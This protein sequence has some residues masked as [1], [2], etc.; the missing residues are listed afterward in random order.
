VTAHTSDDFLDACGSTGPVEILV[1]PRWGDEERRVLPHPFA[2]L[3]RLPTADLVVA[4]EYVSRRHAYL[5]VIAGRLFWIDLLSRSGCYLDE[6]RRPCGWLD[7]GELRCGLH[8]FRALHQGAEARPTW[9]PLTDD[10]PQPEPLA[11]VVLTF[12]RYA[13]PSLYWKPRP[14]VSLIGSSPICKLRTRGDK[15]SRINCVLVRTARGAWIVDL[16]GRGSLRVN[17]TAMR[18]ARLKDGDQLQIGDV[19]IRVQE[20]APDP[21]PLAMADPGKPAASA[22]SYAVTRLLPP[23]LTDGRPSASS[24]EVDGP[25]SIGDPLVPHLSMLLHQFS[26]LQQQMFDQFHQALSMMSQLFGSLHR[27]QMEFIREELNRVEQ[28]TRELNEVKAQLAARPADAA[29]P[30]AIADE[31]GPSEA[32][33][34]PPPPLAASPEEEETSA[35]PAGAGPDTP[36]RAMPLPHSANDGA[37]DI[38]AWLCR[39]MGELQEERQGCWQKILSFLTGRSAGG[40]PG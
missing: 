5:Q 11:S 23:L 28:L 21:G 36:N 29:A 27:D 38:H 1:Q 15:I 31:N 3:G 19:E 24:R 13:R 22:R 26:A 16:L 40:T 39:R 7:A 14:V 33:A 25:Q 6:T 20:V 35:R 17:G 4:D 37:D 18:H 9:N 30:R 32:A 2:L 10:W 34:F 8:R 12:P